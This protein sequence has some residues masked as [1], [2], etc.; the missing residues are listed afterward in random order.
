MKY[1]ID[2]KWH[3]IWDEVYPAVDGLISTVEKMKGRQLYDDWTLKSIFDFLLS[4]RATIMDATIDDNSIHILIQ[5]IK[6]KGR[7]NVVN[8]ANLNGVKTN[9]IPAKL[10]TGKVSESRITDEGLIRVEPYMMKFLHGKDM[11]TYKTAIFINP[12]IDRGKTFKIIDE[13]DLLNNIITDARNGVSI[14]IYA[15]GRL[16]CDV[17]ERIIKANSKY[18]M[19]KVTAETNR[20]GDVQMMFDTPKLAWSRCRT[21]LINGAYSRGI[22]VRF[23]DGRFSKVYCYFDR[24]IGVG[25]REVDQAGNR[26]RGSKEF[27]TCIPKKHNTMK[28]ISYEDVINEFKNKTKHGTYDTL[29][30]YEDYMKLCVAGYNTR[31]MELEHIW[32]KLPDLMMEFGYIVANK[33]GSGGDRIQR[34]NNKMKQLENTSNLIR[35]ANFDIGRI[36]KENVDKLNR[37]KSNDTIKHIPYE[38]KLLSCLRFLPYTEDFITNNKC[39][40]KHIFKDSRRII[41]DLVPRSPSQLNM[42]GCINNLYDYKILGKH[43]AIAVGDN[44][45]SFAEWYNGSYCDRHLNNWY[46][47][48]D[49]FMSEYHIHI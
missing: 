36:T 37:D 35:F 44:L 11:D 19:V 43:L 47:T 42:V 14:V 15:P 13:Y 22:D 45:L 29:S 2:V 8:I 12:H 30:E 32:S 4:C 39:N 17:I 31:A 23:D 49:S 28:C 25:I 6:M 3:F 7:E 20:S 16:D 24:S 21:V 34:I 48:L 33:V 9:E 1:K 10:V 46:D 41:N 40:I 26:N 5:A 38:V 18:K 27:I